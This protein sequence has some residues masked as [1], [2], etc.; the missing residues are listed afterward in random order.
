MVQSRFHSTV[1]LAMVLA[2]MGLLGLTCKSKESSP[3]IVQSLTSAGKGFAVVELFTSEGCS[4]CPAADAAVVRLL[5]QKK[6][7]VFILS[8]HVDYWNRLGWT[9]PFSQA[10]FSDRQ[11][12]YAHAFSLQSI[13]TPQVVVNGAAEFVGSEESRLNKTVEAELSKEA[14]ADLHLQTEQKD[15]T[16]NVMYETAQ[17]DVVL[18]VAL[19][20]PEATTEVKRG[21]NGGRTLHHVNV[22]RAFASA[23]ANGKGIVA[24]SLPKETNADS[25]QLIVYTQ[26]KGNG[27]V[28]AV[29]QH[30]L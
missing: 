8:F 12:Q 9:D 2:F 3:V 24:L 18:N 7:N 13:Y 21:E 11:R 28:T 10:K 17:T 30:F 22:V 15:N 27:A 25:L 5:S 29:Q 26:R 20:Q 6:N 4:S 16:I 1:V 19:V 14:T 23:K